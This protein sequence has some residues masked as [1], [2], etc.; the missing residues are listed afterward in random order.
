MGK[1]L[2]SGIKDAICITA[3]LPLLQACTG[4]GG[5]SGDMPL[6]VDTEPSGAT[7]Y[8]MGKAIGETPISIP[9]QQIYP[10]GYD[11]N[12]A[13]M[14]GTLLIRKTGCQDLRRRIRYQEF[15][16]GL[17]VELNCGGTRS[18]ASRQ[19]SRPAKAVTPSAISP[20]DRPPA[21]KNPEME[22]KPQSATQQSP[23]P[24]HTPK[25]EKTEAG[26]QPANNTVKQRLI[27]IDDLRR[28]GLI[29]EEEYQQARKKI[30]DAL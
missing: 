23:A 4:I 20:Q 17:S 13:P 24:R 12:K 25:T 5:V 27:T 22:Q 21:A 30:L 7:V 9:Q 6:N 19:A 3:C 28:E 26:K 16:T 10:A 2:L 18:S 29:T 11:A 14:Y 8:V 15:N 1:H